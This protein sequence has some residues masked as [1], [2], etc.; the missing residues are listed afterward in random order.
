MGKELGTHA[1]VCTYHTS[2]R[3]RLTVSI[4]T[5]SLCIKLANYLTDSA[6]LPPY[7]L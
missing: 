1:Y 5:L 4:V 3:H 6:E 2:G 7:D